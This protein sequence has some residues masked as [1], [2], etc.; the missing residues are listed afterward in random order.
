MRRALIAVALAGGAL[1]EPVFGAAENPFPTVAAAYV[2][3]VQGTTLWEGRAHERLPP[4]SLTKIMTAMLVIER[5]EL[6]SVVTVST[7]AAA[8]IGA[9]LNLKAGDRM[10]VSDLLIAALVRSANDACLALAEWHSGTESRFV[11][12]MNS[13]A[14]ELHLADTRFA[15]ACGFD[16]ARHYS[17]AA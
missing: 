9:R 15:N 5:G 2:L 1:V 4:A 16:S 12:A 13:R 3:Q 7:R 8:A 10:S 14:G 6:E 17:S 11:R